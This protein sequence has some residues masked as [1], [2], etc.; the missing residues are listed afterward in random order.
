LKQSFTKLKINKNIYLRKRAVLFMFEFELGI[1]GTG[2][3]GSALLKTI[4]KNQIIDNNNIIIYDKDRSIKENLANDYDVGTAE[5]CADLAA[6]SEYILLSVKPQVINTVLEEIGPVMSSKQTIISIAAG[7]ALIH[8]SKYLK[9]DVGIIRIMTN[10]PLLVG[11]G[12]SAIS[13]NNK[14]SEKSIEYVKKIFNSGGIVVELDEVHIDAV[15]GLSGSGPAYFF[16]I[17]EALA[18]G[19]VKMGLSRKIAIQLAA[20]TALGAA[21]LVLETKKHPGELKDMVASPGGTT[22][23]ALHEL[24]NAKLRSTLIR[25]VEVATEK[26]KSLNHS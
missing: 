15:T 19:G 13:H 6:K 5:N 11:A 10:T 14:V 16:V 17:I 12:A 7:V 22:I 23:T 25:A 26:S 20:Q 24:E 4:I 18:D 21:K 1:I 2:T 3:M 8:I 9:E